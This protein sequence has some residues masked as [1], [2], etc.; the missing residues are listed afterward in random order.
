MTHWIHRC[1]PSVLCW[2]AGRPLWSENSILSPRLLLTGFSYWFPTLLEIKTKILTLA[3]KARCGLALPTSPPSS[4]WPLA[5]Q[6]FRPLVLKQ[7]MLLP[8]T[9]P[10]PSH[11][12]SCKMLFPHP[13]GTSKSASPSHLS[14]TCFLQGS[15]IDLSDQGGLLC[16]LHFRLQ[17]HLLLF[18]ITY[19]TAMMWAMPVF[20]P[21]LPVGMDSG[22]LSS[23]WLLAHSGTHRHWLNDHPCQPKPKIRKVTSGHCSC[24]K[25]KWLEV[26]TGH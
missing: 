23:P 9:G 4:S 25:L 22:L 14:W 26:R 2:T 7:D 12:I 16:I 21:R 24:R 13:P 20:S 15:N 6:P 10:S 11:P 5:F 3:Q 18:I 19:S 1:S 17:Y 8:I